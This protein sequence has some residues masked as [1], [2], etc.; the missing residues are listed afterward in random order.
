MR[1]RVASG[2]LVSRYNLLTRGYAG[3]HEALQAMQ[4]G[5][6]LPPEDVLAQAR[7]AT[8]GKR[9]VPQP[10]AAR[11]ENQVVL[12]ERRP[13]YRRYWAPVWTEAGLVESVG[14]VY[15]NRDVN[16]HDIWAIVAVRSSPD[17]PAPAVQ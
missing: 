15:E 4:R 16:D 17:R 7:A 2:A 9:I 12:E 8:G 5:F 3:D 1:Q 11:W 14:L 6:G 10:Y 13:G